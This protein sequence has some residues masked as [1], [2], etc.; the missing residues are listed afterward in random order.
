MSTLQSPQESTGGQSI[1]VSRR[2]VNVVL[3]EKDL[4]AHV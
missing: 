2:F 4:H 3:E 1:D